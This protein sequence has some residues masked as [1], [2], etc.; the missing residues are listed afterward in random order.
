M[1]S[2]E[3][4]VSSGTPL[5]LDDA[6]AQATAAAL[7]PSSVGQVGL[8]LEFH[9]VD[10]REPLRPVSRDELRSLVGSIPPLPSG[11][12]VTTE[13]GG[14][15][16]LSTAVHVNVADSVAALKSDQEVVARAIRGAGFG[17]ASIGADPARAPRRV[18]T[19]SRYV[20]MERHFDA[21]S[22][23]QAGREMMSSTASLQVNLNAGPEAGWADRVAHV[24][25]LGPVLIALSA[26]S[27]FLAGCASGWRSMRQ[28]TWERIDRERCGPMPVDGDPAHAWAAYALAA[29]VMLVRDASGD[30][31][32]A[33]TKR[34]SFA[35]WVAG[36]VSFRRPPTGAD[37]E[38]HLTTL[39]PPV[40]LRGYLE[41]RYL[42]AVPTR[43][44]PALAGIVST[45]IDDEVAAGR[46]AELC[47]GLE[48]LWQTAARRGLHEAALRRAA[49]GCVD[50]A[51]RRCPAE[52]TQTVEDYAELLA[53]GRTPGNELRERAERVGPLAAM[54]EVANE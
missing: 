46:S 51:A 45:L 34:L 27:P 26:C 54:L 31:A 13:P 3:V 19:S 49:I 47:A 10:L 41:I 50:V 36:N 32:Y 6:Y 39:F 15:L 8:E 29:P 9:L 42:D 43:W 18:L 44:W 1:R 22:C 28:Q 48:N 5:T 21:V 35:Q 4:V 11:S 7:T 53:Q 40:R 20:A 2:H 52:L 23:G 37:L 17:L 38:Y 30:S 33:V 24:H 12:A 16:E 14:Q 25:R